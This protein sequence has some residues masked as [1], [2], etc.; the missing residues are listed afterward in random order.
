[1]KKY[2]DKIRVFFLKKK[3]K[4]IGTNVMITACSS[5]AY[6][7]KIIINN[8]V[9]IGPKAFIVA[10]GGLTIEENVIIGPMVTIHTSNHRYENATML[11]YDGYTYIKPVKIKSNVWIG[12][13]VTICPGVTIEEGAVVAMGSVVTKNIPKFA[14]VGGNPA[15]IIK[16]R[17]NILYNTLVD[18]QQFYMKL[19]K[20]KQVVYKD[21]YEI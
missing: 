17:N 14:V 4:K 15:K 6:P 16:M 9:Y 3:F 5:F 1:M 11:P 19:K 12:A 18:Q 10:Y 2:Y 8:H 13:N 21:I 7:E 20:S